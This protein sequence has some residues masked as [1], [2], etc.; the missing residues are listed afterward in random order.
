MSERQTSKVNDSI[1][2]D[3][4]FCHYKNT[5]C[6]ICVYVQRKKYLKANCK[7]PTNLQVF[8]FVKCKKKWWKLI[9]MTERKQD[10]N[11]KILKKKLILFSGI[12]SSTV[13]G[14]ISFFLLFL[15][16]QLDTK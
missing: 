3:A 16:I 7:M 4:R 15:L 12:M 8:D 11:Y 6:K 5:F 14:K 13:A 9:V 1:A 2:D 10:L